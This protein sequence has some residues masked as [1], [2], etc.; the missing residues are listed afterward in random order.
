MKGK[1]FESQ[2]KLEVFGSKK[3]KGPKQDSQ[4]LGARKLEGLNRIAKIS[5]YHHRY[6]RE[7]FCSF[8]A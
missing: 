3:N 7:T 6:T 5:Y 4:N 2:N 8:L 1:I